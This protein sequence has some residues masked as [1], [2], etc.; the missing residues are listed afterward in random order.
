[1]VSVLRPPLQQA[2]RHQNL[3]MLGARYSLSTF[4]STV[5]R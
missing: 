2:S 5:P 4:E 1:M 3:H